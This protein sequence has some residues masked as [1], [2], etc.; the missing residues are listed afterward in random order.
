[1]NAD[2]PR[3]YSIPPGEPFLDVLATQLLNETGGDPLRLSATTVLLPTR[4][5][6]RALGEAFLR[7]ADGKPLVL[8][9]MRPIG[10]VDETALA[11]GD[12]PGF[13][14]LALPP[15]IPALQRELALTELILAWSRHFDEATPE[16][17]ALL[18]RELARLLDQMQTERIPFS[19][20]DR[21]APDEHAD[22]WRDTLAFLE[23]LRTNWPAYLEE[24]SC[25]DPADRR[26]RLLEA[27]AA[28]WTVSPPTEPVIAAGSTGSIPAT[29][30]LLKVVADLPKGR[31]VL[32]GLDRHL[33]GAAWHAVSD[34]PTHPQFGLAVLLSHLGADR[35]DVQDWPV[36]LRD[37]AARDARAGLASEVMRPA[38]TSEAWRAS[39]PPGPE[40]LEGVSRATYA[41]QVEE[42]A[43]IALMMRGALE[44]RTNANTVALV[45][46]DRSLARRVAAEL[47]RWDIAVDDSAGRPLADTPP[48][49]FLRHCLAAAAGGLAPVA[50]LSLLKHPLAGGGRSPAGFRAVARH[51]EHTALRGPRPAAGIAGLKAAVRAAGQGRKPADER[52]I[53]SLEGMLEELARLMEPLLATFGAGTVALPDLVDRL[54]ETAEALAATDEEGGAE[55]LWSGDAGEALASF[56]VDLREYGGGLPPVAADEVPGFFDAM[57]A[58]QMVRPRVGA[59]PRLHIWGVLEARLQNADL[60]IL[61]GLNE[62]SWP[63]EPAADPWMSRPM[64]AQLGLP[65]PEKQIGLSAHD[66]MQGL[67]GRQVV[68]TRAEKVGGQPTVPARWLSRL[69]AVLRLKEGDSLP[70]LDDMRW[71]ALAS[72]LSRS[73]SPQTMP[74]PA[75]RP[76]ADARPTRLSVTRVE[77]WMR[78]PY[79]IYARHILKLEPLD[80]LEADPGAAERGTFVHEA[81]DRFLKAFPDDLPEDALDRLL[82]FGGQAFGDAL[83]QP[84]VRAFWWPRFRRVASWFLDQHQERR[85]NAL[86]LFSEVS[87]ALEIKAP[88]GAFQLTAKAD[89]I[90]C[91]REGGY[92]VIDYKTGTAPSENEVTAGLAPQLPLEAAMVH[93]GAWKEA[94]I[95]GPVTALEY[96][97]LSGGDPP[98]EV[99]LR[100]TGEK[101]KKNALELAD[102][103]RAGLEALVARFQDPDTPYLSVPR[104]KWA[105]RFNDYEHLARVREWSTGGEDPE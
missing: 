58:G 35:E 47:E 50:L 86:S 41:T 68:L 60:A 19:K 88:H 56:L 12:A 4:R 7:I 78:D 82:A 95:E 39:P 3:L 21:L 64:R 90:D 57:L 24:R 73:R 105:P 52:T 22:H 5:A 98:G 31:V 46:A 26:N 37:A 53:A 59:H 77:T 28:A 79:S 91:L 70:G 45:T 13:E 18:A 100:G 14:D 20:L 67:C 84:V 61:G 6:C 74:P 83:A 85:A 101:R 94:V 75:P 97:R 103:A 30:D 65:S 2:R 36:S 81:L 62:A 87:G 32:P 66:F 27:Q 80:P 38:A 96:W 9:A 54:V 51:L 16:H 89:R 8:P 33:D 93:A 29:R 92:V 48:G 63:P 10:D 25:L 55:R 99:V 15:A 72:L 23:I 1:M 42:A 43:A 76:P 49:T 102:E 17:A 40:T 11:L 44:D 71:A 104:P 34:E 69:N